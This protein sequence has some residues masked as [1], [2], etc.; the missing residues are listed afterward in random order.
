MDDEP[1]THELEWLVCS[2]KATHDAA[3]FLGMGWTSHP[4]SA[5]Y[6]LSEHTVHVGVDSAHVWSLVSKLAHKE[7]LI[8]A[9]GG[10]DTGLL[11][12]D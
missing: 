6:P 8:V 12:Q 1:T 10:C 5:P 11:G 2:H 7:S 4:P 9:D 3:C